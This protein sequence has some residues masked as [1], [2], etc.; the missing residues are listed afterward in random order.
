MPFCVYILP[1]SQYE[2]NT[3]CFV[4][5]GYDRPALSPCHLPYDDVGK[6]KKTLPHNEAPRSGIKFAFYSFTSKR[7]ASVQNMPIAGGAS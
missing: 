7:D 3:S 2:I 5:E 6:T 4:V 1:F